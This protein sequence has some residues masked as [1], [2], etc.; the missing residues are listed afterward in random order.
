MSENLNMKKWPW[1]LLMDVMEDKADVEAIL[2]NPPADLEATILYQV[3]TLPTRQANGVNAQRMP[4]ILMDHYCK[5][6]TYR[7]IGEV[8]GVT[9]EAVHITANKALEML[10][11]PSCVETFRTGLRNAQ[12]NRVRRVIEENHHMLDTAV[13]DARDDAYAAGYRMGME[14]ALNGNSQCRECPDTKRN[15]ALVY[16]ADV[17]VDVFAPD[18]RVYN[19][20]MRA[21]LLT[22]GDVALHFTETEGLKSIRGLGEL[23]IS[24]LLTVLQEKY[25]VQLP[26]SEKELKALKGARQASA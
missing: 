24:R 25:D 6:I 2:N 1:N 14:D 11:R 10:R 12:D 17:R 26:A 5:G 23:S 7:E 20:L 9:R 22:I 4:Q 3:Y 21:N 8:F 18:V 16:A 19:A 15:Y 13:Q